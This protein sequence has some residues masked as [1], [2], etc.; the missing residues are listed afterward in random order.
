VRYIK[1]STIN[2]L[3]Y[4][5]IFFRVNYVF[6]NT[7]SNQYYTSDLYGQLYYI[8]DNNIVSR[9]STVFLWVFILSFILML[10]FVF[11]TPTFTTCSTAVSGGASSGRV[12]V[13]SS[14]EWV[15]EMETFV[16]FTTMCLYRCT[17]VYTELLVSTEY[18]LYVYNVK[19]ISEI[20]NTKLN[21]K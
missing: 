3:R 17:I 16:Y 7:I 10:T 13:A 1:K 14:R 20:F 6:E 9:L 18:L 5:C 21:N 19:Y 12:R 4:T 11:R 15:A 8:Y 2:L